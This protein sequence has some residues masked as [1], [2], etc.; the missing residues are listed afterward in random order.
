M[1]L[2]LLTIFAAPQI[3]N[4]AHSINVLFVGDRG[5]HQP[6]DR[7]SDVYGELVRAG[8]AVDYE[9]DLDVINLAV[10]RQYDTVVMYANQAQHAE[11]PFDFM[12][13]ITRYV[14]GGG[15]F[16][17]LHCTSGCFTQSDAWLKFIGARFES[18]GG[19]V[20]KQQLVGEHPLLKGWQNFEAWDETY[21]Q[22]HVEDDR[23]ILSMRGDEPWSWVRDVGKGRLFYSASGHDARVWT[24]PGFFD[25]LLRAIVYTA[26]DDA[27][28]RKYPQFEY[29]AEEWVPNYEQRDPQDLM[30]V[31]STPQQALDSLVVPAGMHAEL[32][33]CEPMVINPIA[34][35]FDEAGRCWVVESP[36]YP[37][38]RDGGD[39]VS[40]LED[41]DGDGFADKKTVFADGLN[42]PTSVLKVD[43][44]VLVTQAPELL[45]LKDTDGDDVCDERQV[46]LSGFGILDTHAGP[47]NLRWGLDNYIWGTVGYSGYKSEAGSFGSGLWRWKPGLEHPEFMAQFSNNTWGIGFTSKGEIWGSTANNAPSFFV[48]MPSQALAK[49]VFESSKVH[50]ALSKIRQGDFFGSFTAATSH[51][52][53]TGD[54]LP[55]WWNEKSAFIC[56]PTAHLISRQET[57]VDGSGFR[58]RDCFNVVS[59]VDDWFCPVQ[60][61]IGPDGALW[62]AD[63][64]QFI[65]LH[66]LPGNPERGL[67]AI[68]FDEGNA[69]LNPLRDRS[70]GRIFRIVRDGATATPEFDLGGANADEVLPAL[71]ST[72]KFW[73]VTARRLLVE[74][75]MLG[76]AGIL[77]TIVRKHLNGNAASELAGQEALRVLHGFDSYN[78]SYSAGFDTVNQIF[79]SQQQAFGVVALDMMPRNAKFS[80][81][82]SDSDL[83]FSDDKN[84]QRH[85]LL[86]A[87]EM[88]PSYAIAGD[89]L[90]AAKDIDREDAWLPDAL[91]MAIK[92]H[93]EQFAELA[94]AEVEGETQIAP[95]TRPLFSEAF[96][97]HT[98]SGKGEF[99]RDGEVLIIESE[100]GA[101]CAYQISSE[102]I[103]GYQYRYQGW[104]K[105]V[106]LSHEGEL[107]SRGALLNIHHEKIVS[108]RVFEDSDWR[109]VTLDFET[110][111]DQR[112]VTLNCL[113]GGWGQSTGT[114]YYKDLTLTA[115]APSNSLSAYLKYAQQ[116]PAQNLIGDAA[117]GQ[118]VYENNAANCMSCHP[119]VGPDLAGIGQRLTAAE[120]KE[121]IIN[122]SASRA[123]GWEDNPAV[124]TEA[125]N[126][127]SAQDIADLVEFL[128]KDIRVRTD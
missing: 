86:A 50:P 5:F 15:G 42:L 13:A 91:K 54:Q 115:V 109:L 70:H 79:S 89:L 21:V 33:A 95:Q 41:T 17:G 7:L 62:V 124:M 85:A 60:I 2:A 47:A 10:L 14:R 126:F 36:G 71:Y 27:Q 39:S 20:F 82:L 112:V 101:D 92:T 83:I 43:G 119:G 9:D 12:R 55:E 99:T 25:M 49:P 56:E 75:E 106:N 120:I 37:A 107:Y 28:L 26:G 58:T 11:V 121:A 61:D 100:N 93:S 128:T 29:V 64:S 110:T 30:Q 125:L 113:Y 44:G 31:A 51:S 4:E 81:L 68:D 76:A 117:R 90:I 23:T 103:G 46:L 77:H 105:T 52:F 111:I 53:S 18:H 65:I 66:N 127:L 98:Y 67:P 48:G 45:F 84:I 3:N 73:R 34:L 19:E 114:A 57:Y 69:H 80:Q 122:P 16:V 72:N 8:V 74:Q 1:L 87:A 78:D 123:E 116:Q 108:E 6:V 59:S 35:A 118:D 24:T 94:A 63:F 40:I 97:P 38:T 22:T 88:Q 96:S 32:F 102:V 104:V